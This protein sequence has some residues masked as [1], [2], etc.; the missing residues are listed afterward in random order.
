MLQIINSVNSSKP[1]KQVKS[2]AY[3]VMMTTWILKHQVQLS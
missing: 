1:C 3:A 2:N